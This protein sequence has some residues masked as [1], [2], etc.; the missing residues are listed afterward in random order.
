VGHNK[1]STWTKN[2]I[3]SIMGQLS[4]PEDEEIVYEDFEQENSDAPSEV[5]WVT[6][7]AVTP[8]KDQ[9]HCGS[10]WA[11]SAVGTLEGAHAIKSGNL[12]SFSEQQLVDC[13]KNN[14]GCR[15]GL[16]H[17]AFKYWKS[18]N[19]ELESAYPY[20][21]K[22]GKCNYEESSATAIGVTS[23][24]YVIPR[25]ANHM[26]KGLAKQP[27]SV[28]I[29]A[30]ADCFMQYE[31]GVL[32]CPKCGSELDHAVLAVGYG[33]DEKSGLDYW[34]IKNSWGPDWGEDGYIRMAITE[35]K[36]TCGVQMWPL[37]PT[38]NQ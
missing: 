11:F 26:R 30:D 18:S 27:L 1:F 23:W 25:S 5:N 29:N 31:S 32:D 22:H 4:M 13:D 3:K 21:G 33:T 38:T 36:G 15:G 20:T 24:R 12:L 34:L 14:S 8:V 19:A 35:G 16:Q 28:S 2:E 9:G 6:A 7:G 10:C 17:Y 37:Y